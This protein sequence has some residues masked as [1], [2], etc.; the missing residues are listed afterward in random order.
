MR[1]WTTKTGRYW[2]RQSE[3]REQK[4]FMVLFL[5]MDTSRSKW[6]NNVAQNAETPRKCSYTNCAPRLRLCIGVYCKS[7]YVFAVCVSWSQC[8]RIQTPASAGVTK[9]NKREK[10]NQV[11]YCVTSKAPRY[12][13]NNRGT[14]AA[15][16]TV[17]AAAATTNTAS[18]YIFYDSTANAPFSHPRCVRL[19]FICWC[20]F[21]FLVS[22]TFGR[23][24][25]AVIYYLNTRNSSIHWVRIVIGVRCSSLCLILHKHYV[26]HRIVCDSNSIP[27]CWF[28]CSFLA[29]S[30]F[31]TF[32]LVSHAPLPSVQQ[33]CRLQWTIRL[34]KFYDP[35]NFKHETKKLTKRAHIQVI[36]VWLI[37][38]FMRKINKNMVK[39]FASEWAAFRRPDHQKNKNIN[40]LI[41]LFVNW[42]YVYRAS[43]QRQY[44]SLVRGWMTD[45]G[46]ITKKKILSI[47]L[48]ACPVRHAPSFIQN[49]LQL[50]PRSNW[51][52]AVLY[53]VRCLPP[54][55]RLVFC[56]CVHFGGAAWRMTRHMHLIK[57]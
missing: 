20:F 43:G 18:E 35:A 6:M 47:F 32:L 55:H 29:S 21:Y 17:A 22:S 9:V 3:C 26:M 36:I 31:T 40:K 2:M 53:D 45:M 44:M 52:L 54:P 25:P 1:K 12:I 10:W 39:C 42:K 50:N 7:F 48:C 28:H 14:P 24:Y 49:L 46:W 57:V 11:K 16:T 34:D 23:K 4:Y 13:S 51:C 19:H 8:A 27:R 38:F 15:P 33:R 30:F 5:I 41:F 56:D 37:E